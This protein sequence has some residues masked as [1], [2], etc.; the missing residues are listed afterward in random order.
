[1]QI[2]HELAEAMGELQRVDLLACWAA[3]IAQ[4]H[5][6]DS[7]PPSAWCATSG[8]LANSE[9]C[10]FAAA[11]QADVNFDPKGEPA[12]ATLGQMC[13]KLNCS[14]SFCIMS[15]GTELPIT[16]MVSRC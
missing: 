6:L 9:L 13:V 7:F 11:G 2:S 4:Q 15:L 16:S 1:M 14:M 5:V 12:D 8:Q 10:M 3:H